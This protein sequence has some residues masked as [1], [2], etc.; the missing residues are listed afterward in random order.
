MFTES[1]V[2]RQTDI[3]MSC[4]I[5]SIKGYIENLTFPAGVTDSGLADWN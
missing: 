3:S 4:N 1:Q 5:S 2:L